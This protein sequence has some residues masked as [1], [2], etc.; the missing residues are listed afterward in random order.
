MDNPSAPPLWQRPAHFYLEV[1]D[2]FEG[3][4]TSRAHLY[5][6]GQMV[7]LDLSARTH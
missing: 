7:V 4:M 2:R 1:F 6:D 3:V 5:D